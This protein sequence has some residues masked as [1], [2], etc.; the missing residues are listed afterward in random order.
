MPKA[1]AEYSS[2]VKAA[3]WAPIVVAA[4][5]IV[6][7]LYAW[8]ITGSASLLASL[9]DSLLDVA[10]STINFFVIRYALMPADDEHRFGHGKAESLAGLA[11]SAFICGSSILL[12]FHSIDRLLNPHNVQHIDI[13]Y[14]VTGLAIGLTAML[15]IF[16]TWV[17]RKTQSIAIK[18]DSLHY[19]GDLLMNVAIMLALFLTSMGYQQADAIFAILIAIYMMSSAWE[20]AR[21]S[22]QHLMD[23]ELPEAEQQQIMAIVVAQEGVHGAHDL[24]TRQAGQIKFVQL[25]LELDDSLT[26]YEAHRIADK[27]ED[28]IDEAFDNV[29]VLIHQDPLSVVRK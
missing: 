7:K 15:V 4:I 5:L 10:A 11:Q 8:T 14:V 13:G 16:Q 28:A 21:E 27:V 20:V 26:L 17:V 9:T 12:I 6:T 18:A 29:D 24:R 3:S 19:K 25:H 22:S 2:L 1:T 23:R